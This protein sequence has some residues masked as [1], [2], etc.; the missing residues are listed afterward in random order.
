MKKLTI[1]FVIF[2]LFQSI[3]LGKQYNVLV[4]Q[5]DEHHK[6]RLDA[7]VARSSK[8]QTSIGLQKMGQWLQ[9]FMLLHQ[10]ALPR[11]HR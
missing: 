5:T 9:V 11:E 7:M 8:H 10:F 6:K 2:V 1:T 4:I 3:S